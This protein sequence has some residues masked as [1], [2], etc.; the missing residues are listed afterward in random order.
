LRELGIGWIAAYSP[1][2]KGRIENGSTLRE[3]GTFYFALTANQCSVSM[4]RTNAATLYRNGR[5]KIAKPD[6]QTRPANAAS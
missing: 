4:Q 6:L 5:M 2:A 3:S 1:Q